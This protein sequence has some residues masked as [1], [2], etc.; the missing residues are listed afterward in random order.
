MALHVVSKYNL[1]YFTPNVLGNNYKQGESDHPCASCSDRRPKE[2]DSSPKP[3]APPPPPIFRPQRI[4]RENYFPLCETPQLCRKV[5]YANNICRSTF[6]NSWV[7]EGVVVVGGG[8]YGGTLCTVSEVP[9]NNV[10][11][12]VTPI[13]SPEAIY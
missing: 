7:V 5:L 10:L 2:F 4:N 12:Q 13:L 3:T 6:D 9:L 11:W 1:N 8:S